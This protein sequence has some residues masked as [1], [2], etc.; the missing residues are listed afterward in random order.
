MALTSGSSLP[1]RGW[2][3]RKWSLSS[4]WS[5]QLE[6]LRTGHWSLFCLWPASPEHTRL[7]KSSR[8]TTM[9]TFLTEAQVYIERW[10]ILVFYSHFFHVSP[11]M[12][13]FAD[14]LEV[15]SSTLCLICFICM[16]WFCLSTPN[17][18]WICSKISGLF[19]SLIFMRSFRTMMMFWVRS[20]AP[21]LELF[22]AA[23]E[24]PGWGQRYK[25]KEIR[26]KTLKHIKRELERPYS[27]G[28]LHLV[29]PGTSRG[30]WHHIQNSACLDG[31]YPKAALRI[32]SSRWGWWRSTPQSCGGLWR[33]WGRWEPA[34]SFYKRDFSADGTEQRRV[35]V[36]SVIQPLWILTWDGKPTSSSLPRV[37]EAMAEVIP[38][39][40]EFCTRD[41]QRQ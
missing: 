16:P 22:S 31:R 40:R 8:N 7:R 20:S 9:H 39:L 17:T 34:G 33:K 41:C 32:R 13:I 38:A 5:Y 4:S 19:L 18:S 29:N 6:Q 21:C 11:V 15:P 23:P 36:M 14:H 12:L 10:W 35:S 26:S 30:I 28:S 37:V 25:K 2:G 3:Y 27:A 24:M 1:R